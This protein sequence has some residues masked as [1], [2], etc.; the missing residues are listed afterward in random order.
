MEPT[1]QNKIIASSL[2]GAPLLMLLADLAGP[3]LGKEA[4]FWYATLLLWFSFYAYLGA[5]AGLVKLSG[6]TRLAVIG[7]MIALLGALIGTTIMGLERVGWA[8]SMQEFTREQIMAT[9]NYPVVFFTSRAPGL[10]FPIGL[11]ILTYTLYKAGQ[12]SLSAT[13]LLAVGVILF[14]VGRIV[15]GAWANVPGDAIMLVVY[16]K[17]SV[18]IFQAFAEM[19]EEQLTAS[20]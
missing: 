12:L 11:L 8:M 18:D 7:A 13:L 20:S 9:I 16:G 2:I 6:N 5:I 19:P 14:P 17:L 4:G 3:V 1:L 10:T 15:A